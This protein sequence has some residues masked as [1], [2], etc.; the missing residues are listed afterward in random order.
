MLW[1]HADKKS[2]CYIRGKFV[3]FKLVK[4]TIQTG[5]GEKNQLHLYFSMPALFA[6]ALALL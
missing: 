3:F 2:S 6:V 1:V 4:C 5:V